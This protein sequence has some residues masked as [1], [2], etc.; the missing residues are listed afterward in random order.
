MA[1]IIVL[2]MGLLVK[3][4]MPEAHLPKYPIPKPTAA[5]ITRP[6]IIFIVMTLFY[7]FT[8]IDAF[9]SKGFVLVAREKR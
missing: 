3:G 5:P 8:S 9:V 7:Y 1:P 6:R 2:I 4:H